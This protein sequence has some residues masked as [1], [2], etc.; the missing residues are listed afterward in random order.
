MAFL[1]G[2]ILTGYIFAGNIDEKVDEYI[3]KEMSVRQIPGLA[4]AVVK[5]G[6]IIKIKN[7]GVSSIEFN[8]SVNKQ[9][10][11]PLYSA[12]K[13][14]AGIAVMKL[15]EEGKLSLDAPVTDFFDN[16]P[17]N[18]KS[19]KLRNLL[20]HTSGLPE[21]TDNSVAK[22]LPEDRRKQLTKEEKL[23]FVAE[24]P[25]RSQPGEKFS[26][27]RFGYVL[28]GM[29]IEKITGKNYG[30]FLNEQIFRPFGMNSTKYGDSSAVINNRTS[31]QYILE[32]GKLNN[33]F[34]SFGEN[35]PGAGL[36][37]T[38]TDL[39]RFLAAFDTG[40][41]IN[42]ESMQL[43]W[44]PAKLNNGQESL[45]GLG[46]NIKKL[47]GQIAVGHEGGGAAWV[48]Y[49]PAEHISIVILCNLNGA[50]ADEMQYK[51]GDIY[52]QGSGP[53]NISKHPGMAFIQGTT[54]DMGTDK[55]RISSLQQKFNIKRAEL[56]S[57]E[58]PLHRVQ[59]DSFYLDKYEVTNAEYKKFLDKNPKWRPDKIPAR[60]HNGKYL[61]NWVGGNFPKEQAKYPVVFVPW[62]AAVAFC[63]AEDKRLPT[64]AEWEYAARGGL[65]DKDF[66]W[67]DEPV[68][69][70][71]ANY[72]GSGIGAAT[73]VGNYP[74]NGYG[75]FD[76][77]GNVWEYLSD[78][79]S[80]YPTTTETLV[81]PV[82]GGNLFSNDSY[83]E[84]KTR[85]VIRGGSW[86]GAP[87]NLRITYRDSHQ[88]ANA[89][90]HVG[91]RCAQTASLQ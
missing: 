89:G 63:Q 69:K 49:Y 84:I 36:N 1:Y 77:A 80:A 52:L 2:F 54:F 4:L 70:T 21:W 56:F 60:F 51:I 19:I 8:L 66:P 45:Y 6:K 22:N 67:G 9:T 83:T 58:S 55:S 48:T 57:E 78:E 12:T 87:I 32:K 43:L 85:R 40:K 18:W 76:M 68:D 81:N 16:L 29:I 74:P 90:D 5:N 31:T 64:E 47:K 53:T 38:V 33:T 72:S 42:P 37:S 50:R 23:T 88:P 44:T 28:L 71:R 59:I 20:T 34:I 61:N 86:G 11:F 41:V 25:L 13:I 24:T 39:A 82:A 46:W 75:L 10:V 65:T 62:Y 79:W 30:E 91:F 35:D 27:H 14:F 3:Q 26:Y 15:I 7:Y 17:P 73:A